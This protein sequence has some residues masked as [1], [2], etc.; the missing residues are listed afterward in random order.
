[1]ELISFIAISIN[2][3]VNLS[4][5]TASEINSREFIVIRDGKNIGVINSH[6]TSARLNNYNFIDNLVEPGFHTYNLNEVDLNGIIKVVGEKQIYVSGPNQ[7]VLYQNFPNPFNPS[8]EISF[9]VP[10]EDNVE[11]RIYNQLG[12]ECSVLVNE[13]LTAGYYHRN[14]SPVAMSSGIYIV[15]LKARNALLT[16]KMLY[17]K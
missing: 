17:L 13:R 3:N 6:G 15:R 11:I 5:T 4:W 14:F 1:V 12:Q 7:F 16:N 9:F 2:N 10:N 8:T